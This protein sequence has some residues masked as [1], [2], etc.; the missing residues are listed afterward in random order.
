MFQ[1]E[2]PQIQIRHQLARHYSCQRSETVAPLGRIILLVETLHIGPISPLLSARVSSF[3]FV[4]TL[5]FL[6]M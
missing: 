5:Q 1:S 2:L 6:P 3:A 4:L